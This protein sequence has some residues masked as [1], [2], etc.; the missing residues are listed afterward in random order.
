[1]HDRHCDKLPELMKQKDEV[2]QQ[3][4]DTVSQKE[5]ALTT[6]L[7]EVDS[8]QAELVSMKELNDA[9]RRALTKKHCLQ[10]SK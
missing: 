10:R 9:Y 1:M 5:K 2:K 3:V 4:H 7:D 8:T 6:Q